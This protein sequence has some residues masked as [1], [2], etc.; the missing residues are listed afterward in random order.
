MLQGSLRLPRFH[1]VNHRF[2]TLLSK[3]RFKNEWHYKL[4]TFLLKHLAA[5]TALSP[6][7]GYV[8]HV[9]MYVCVRYRTDGI[10]MHTRDPLLVLHLGAFPGR[11]QSEHHKWA[12]TS[13][14]WTIWP[15][16]KNGRGF[17]KAS[18]RRGFFPLLPCQGGRLCYLSQKELRANR[19]SRR[20]SVLN[21]QNPQRDSSSQNTK[22][23]RETVQDVM[24]A[25]T[26]PSPIQR[27]M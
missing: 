7:A 15:V 18:V 6:K 10:W 8:L 16:R 25:R 11:K 2:I 20:S 21:L 3:V 26:A 9:C 13:K 14:S 1:F 27:V 19:K 24:L 4:H 22:H 17:A 23:S 12:S 5:N